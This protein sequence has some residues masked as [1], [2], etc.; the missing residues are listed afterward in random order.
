MAGPVK[1]KKG[2]REEGRWKR[3]AKFRLNVVTLFPELF[4]V[5]FA[6]SILGRAK[7]KGRVEYRVVNLP[8]YTHDRDHTGDQAP[9]GGGGRGVSD[10]EPF[11]RKLE[12]LAA[13][14]PVTL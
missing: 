10:P 1:E 4:D 7:T 11:F 14:P 5:A 12:A 6:T 13:K 2:K 8:D 9:E 3:T